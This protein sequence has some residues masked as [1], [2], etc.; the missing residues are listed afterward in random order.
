MLVL[1]ATSRW[2]VL[3]SVTQRSLTISD[4]VVPSAL[5]LVRWKWDTEDSSDSL[6]GVRNPIELARLVLDHSTLALSLRRV[7]PNLLVGSG[8]TDYAEENEMK[9]YHPDVLISPG[10]GERYRK[11]KT[12][13]EKAGPHGEDEDLDVFKSSAR[14]TSSMAG[15]PDAHNL[16]EV[17]CW[18]ESQ[19]YSPSLTAA[20]TSSFVDY[21][22][23]ARSSPDSRKRRRVSSTVVNI[24]GKELKGYEIDASMDLDTSSQSRLSSMDR[25][26]GPI[27]PDVLESLGTCSDDIDITDDRTDH[28]LSLSDQ[29]PQKSQHNLHIHEGAARL[30]RGDNITDTVGAIAVDCFGN[31]AAGS[32]SG[33]IGMKHKGRVGPAALVG[34]GTAVIPAEEG[35][36]RQ[37]SVAAVTSGTGEHMATSMAAATCA[38][39]LY[40]STKRSDRGSS[41][42][43]DDDTAI[44][45]FVE[46]DFMGKEFYTAPK[47]Q[48]F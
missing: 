40:T 15:Q 7:P 19:P 16:T 44:K 28:I 13:L 21:G 23:S 33:G 6:T 27:R 37:L 41:E 10:A 32:S 12:E 5:Y 34:I 1:G 39:R 18:N 29:T 47:K 35:D 26:I 11:W 24:E 25:K 9:T 46:R 22:D 43:T 17:P 30:L 31:I 3:W 38:N 48:S 45:T 14:Q 20:E 8:A 4:A 36:E 2:K 42:S